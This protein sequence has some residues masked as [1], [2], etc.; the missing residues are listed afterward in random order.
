MWAIML[1]DN[2]RVHRSI[3]H[4]EVAT[5]THAKIDVIVG[6]DRVCHSKLFHDVGTDSRQRGKKRGELELH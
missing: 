2:R 3:P 6:D 5:I 4:A 1:R